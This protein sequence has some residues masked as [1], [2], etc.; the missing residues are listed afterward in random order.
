MWDTCPVQIEVELPTDL[1][2]KVEAIQ[3]ADPEFMSKIVLYGLTR[4][5]LYEHLR[6]SSEVAQQGSTE[7]QAVF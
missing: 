2:K 7:V 4:R 3:K 1:A 6:G 5:T